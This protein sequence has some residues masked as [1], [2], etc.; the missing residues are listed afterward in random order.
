MWLYIEFDY[1]LLPDNMLLNKT[2]GIVCKIARVEYD[3]SFFEV[4][5]TKQN[6]VKLIAEEFEGECL[7]RKCLPIK[8][9]VCGNTAR[10]YSP[11]PPP[12]SPS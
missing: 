2:E 8:D 12:F 10:P 3:N 4:V 5:I 7:A 11:L 1:G 6:E 9:W